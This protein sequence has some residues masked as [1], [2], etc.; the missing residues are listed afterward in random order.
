MTL[1]HCLFCMQ[2]CALIHVEGLWAEDGATA[3]VRLLHEQVD[4]GRSESRPSL[5]NAR[6]LA[7][8]SVALGVTGSADVMEFRG[9]P[10]LPFPVEYKRGKRR[11]IGRMR[12][13][14]APKRS[15]WR[16]CSANLSR[17]R[18]VLW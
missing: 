8:R 7:L 17:R 13:S 1:Q 12:C 14:F 16:R 10:P 4:A 18:V 3:A 2:Q 6:A 15:A 11:R 5:R 9:H